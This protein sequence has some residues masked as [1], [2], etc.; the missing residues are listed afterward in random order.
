MRV[1]APRPAPSSRALRA[2]SARPVLLLALAAWLSLAAP[3]AARDAVVLARDVRVRQE[4]RPSARVLATVQPGDRLEFAGVGPKRDLPLYAVD[5][6]GDFWVRVRMRDGR[7]GYVKND[8]V[9][10]VREEIR[11]RR[12]DHF[13]IVNLRQTGDGLTARDLWVIRKDWAT[14]RYLG[15]IDGTPV[16]GASGD[17]FISQVDSGVQAGGD[18]PRPV[19]RIDRYSRDGRERRTLAVGFAVAVL[20]GEGKI[21]FLNDVDAQG[22]PAPPSVNA[23]NLD[24]STLEVIF[25]LPD[26]MRFWKEEGDY[27]VHAPPPR[28]SADGHLVALVAYDREGVETHFVVTVDG[29]LIEQIPDRAGTP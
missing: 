14:T 24:G 28:L 2:P 10:A 23:V 8:V 13:L 4:A 21:L 22:N 26:G 29:Q 16:W 17:W 19:E 7:E 20:E 3:A 15:A 25:E 18:V 9:A 12:G 6:T 1:R 11:P 27:F 5:P